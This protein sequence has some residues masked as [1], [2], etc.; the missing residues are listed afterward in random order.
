MSA[1]DAPYHAALAKLGYE[2]PPTA[3]PETAQGALAAAA[4]IALVDQEYPD[5]L[6]RFAAQHEYA[7]AFADMLASYF[8]ETPMAW[9]MF[10]NQLL[11]SMPQAV[12]QDP[13]G[14]ADVPALALHIAGACCTLTSEAAELGKEPVHPV[15][16]RSVQ[17]VAQIVAHLA[18]LADPAYVT[19]SLQVREGLC[20][21]RKEHEPHRHESGSLGVFWCTADESQRLPFAAERRRQERS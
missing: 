7:R 13:V 11:L 16:L 19:S 18:P 5:T 20:G 2:L 1:P 8:P 4:F 6:A 12:L 14:T 9:S 3:S 17:Q 21:N 15:L 10:L